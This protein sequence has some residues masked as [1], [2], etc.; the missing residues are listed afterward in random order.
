MEKEKTFKISLLIKIALLVIACIL[1]GFAVRSCVNA[2]TQD[3]FVIM[4]S[5]DMHGRYWDK[6]FQTNEEVPVNALSLSTAV[7]ETKDQFDDRTVLFDNGDFY[8]GSLIE[9]FNL[10]SEKAGQIKNVDPC[11]ICL[12]EMKYDGFNLG[13]HEFDYKYSLV[14]E[15]YEYIKENCSLVSAN[16]Y[17]AKTGE[18]IF[19]PYFTKT[20]KVDG[21][22]L[23]VGVIG[24]ENT[25][26]S[27]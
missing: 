16:I 22:F 26:C 25:D 8:Q 12:D 20:F 21:Q 13:N 6:D 3:Q 4:S 27:L 2:R 24:L 17:N 5:S 7:K 15:N 9:S 10:T 11:T 14:Q 1:F 19:K 23:K 18:R